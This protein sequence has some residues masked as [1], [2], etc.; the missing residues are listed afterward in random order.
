MKRAKLNILP[1]EG[2]P[3]GTNSV[4]GMTPHPA[5]FRMDACDALS[6]KGRGRIYKRLLSVLVCE[7][8]TS[9]RGRP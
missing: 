2:S 8:V 1:G 3:H 9:P 5:S 6:R 7:N 4:L